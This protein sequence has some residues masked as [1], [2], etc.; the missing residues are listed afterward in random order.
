MLAFIAFNVAGS[1]AFLK[2]KPEKKETP[3][4]I[5]YRPQTPGFLFLG[6]ENNQLSKNHRP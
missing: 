1:L 2:G 4:I 6:S 5:N 3:I